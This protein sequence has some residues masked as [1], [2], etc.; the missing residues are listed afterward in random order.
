MSRCLPADPATLEV[1]QITYDPEKIS[2]EQLLDVFWRQIDPTDGGGSFVDRGPQYR[3]A[4]FYHNK[5]Q[6]QAAEKSKAELSSSGRYNGPIAT[7]ILQ[8][9]TFYPAEDYHQDYYKKK[10]HTV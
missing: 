3:S 2:Y 6:K 10:S 4:V 8:A 9:G 1:I 5:M 7:E